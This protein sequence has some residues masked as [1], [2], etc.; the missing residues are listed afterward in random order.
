MAANADFVQS[1]LLHG[2]TRSLMDPAF[3]AI[4]WEP[5]SMVASV[6]GCVAH[7]ETVTAMNAA[8]AKAN[9]LIMINVLFKWR[10]RNTDRLSLAPSRR[11]G[12]RVLTGAERKFLHP[13]DWAGNQ[14]NSIAHRGPSA[15]ERQATQR[16]CGR[17]EDA[18]GASI[19]WRGTWCGRRR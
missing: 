14:W 12:C 8:P 16:L 9:G 19:A 1:E 18:R 5:D 15:F 7:A 3:G 2:I 11:A 10:A 4:G 13:L 6:C 17:N